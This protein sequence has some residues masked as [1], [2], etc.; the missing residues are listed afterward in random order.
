MTAP[1]STALPPPALHLHQIAYSPESLAAVEPGFE[2]L[3]NR[4]NPRP[5]WYEYE[6]VRCFLLT[7]PLDEAAFYGFFSTKFGA[8]TGHTRATVD[9]LLA[10]HGHDADVL[11][12]SAHPNQIAFFLNVFE[13]GEFFHP[14]LM[15]ATR[16][17]LH[18]VGL[19]IE[20]ARLLMDV[21]QTVFCNFFIARP[22]FWRQWLALGERLWA[23]CEGPATPLQQRLT[24][25]TDYRGAAQMKIF[26]MERLA[27][28]VLTLQPTWRSVAA[29]PY[30]NGL[31]PHESLK[32]DPSDAITSDALKH[33]MQSC[34][35]P[36]YASAFG[37]VRQ[38]VLGGAA[39]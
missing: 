28:L 38:R 23:V 6:P 5:D 13:Q 31:W 1:R 39:A 37:H 34:G 7:Q 27:S 32:R 11:L 17:W 14:G 4:A 36:E 10:R 35:W 22:A 25:A 20:P 3:D 26:L 8:K 30:A 29:D 21:R 15:N 24:A 19:P 12:F 16:D 18:E 2:V 9:A 33:A